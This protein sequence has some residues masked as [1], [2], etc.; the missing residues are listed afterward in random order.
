MHEMD[1][2]T[3]KHILVEYQFDIPRYAWKEKEK[4]IFRLKSKYGDS[5]DVKMAGEVYDEIVGP[6]IETEVEYEDIVE[7]DLWEDPKRIKS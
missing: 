3:I 5:F 7:V 6:H 4:V 2:A 1:K